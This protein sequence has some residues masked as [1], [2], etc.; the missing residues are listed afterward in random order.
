MDD[1]RGSID[2]KTKIFFFGKKFDFGIDSTS[3]ETIILFG[4][5]AISE[6]SILIGFQP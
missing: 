4:I 3:A 5:F 1:L 6:H 2:I